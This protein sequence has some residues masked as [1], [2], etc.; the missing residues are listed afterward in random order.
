M[1]QNYHSCQKNLLASVAAQNHY[2]AIRQT[3]DQMLRK[4]NIKYE[5]WYYFG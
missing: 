3:K 2:K 4:Q 1:K 5:A